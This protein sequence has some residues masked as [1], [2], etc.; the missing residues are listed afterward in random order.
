[1]S[2]IKLKQINSNLAYDTTNAT[3]TLT[4]SFVASG[5][6]VF[7]QVTES[8][9]AITISGSGYVVDSLVATGSFNIDNYDTFGDVSSPDV[10][11][12]GTF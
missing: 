11:D 6:S 7:L 10:E 8:I 1:M 4:G 12:L 2:R 9:P 3:L 5:S